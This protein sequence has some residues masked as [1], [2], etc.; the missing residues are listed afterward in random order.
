MIMQNKVE[1]AISVIVHATEN[2][3]KVINAI[4]EL[5]VKHD[6]FEFTETTGHYNNMITIYNAKITGND[7]KYFMQK[8]TEMISKDDLD[9]LIEQSPERTVDSRLHIR[10]D[11]QTIIRDRR[12][13][14]INLYESDDESN[15]Q[16]TTK[17]MIKIKIFTPIYNKKDTAKVFERILR[18]ANK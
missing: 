3:D 18:T 10:I 4:S 16:N 5:G 6:V 1:V 11:K 2:P 17:D 13:E 7:A 8:F 14:I 12:I 15:Q 9:M